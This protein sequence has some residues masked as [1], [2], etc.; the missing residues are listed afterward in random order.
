MFVLLQGR[1]IN[2]IKVTRSENLCCGWYHKRNQNH[3]PYPNHRILQKKNPKR[4][5]WLVVYDLFLL[6]KFSGLIWMLK[7]EKKKFLSILYYNYVNSDGK[8]HLHR[9][10][11]VFFLYIYIYIY[12]LLKQFFYKRKI[13]ILLILN[14][15]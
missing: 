5:H 11:S 6:D 12:Q 7:R 10:I 15:V 8:I 4:G 14:R 9:I 13:M 3:F 1:L 2:V